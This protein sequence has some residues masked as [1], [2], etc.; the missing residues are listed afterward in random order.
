M[1]KCVSVRLFVCHVSAYSVCE[2]VCRGEVLH[3][4]HGEVLHVRHGEVLHVRHGE[5]LRV[6]QCKVLHC[7]WAKW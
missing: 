2:S 6:R 5:V 4:R 3:V 7:L 1:R